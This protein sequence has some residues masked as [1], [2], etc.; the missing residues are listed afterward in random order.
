MGRK[1]EILERAAIECKYIAD[2]TNY[3]DAAAYDGFIIGA[4]W[5]DTSILD[6]VVDYLVEKSNE[7]IID[8]HH[9]EKFVNDLKRDMLK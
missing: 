2:T 8:L 5:V 9:N 7:G 1:E 6:K 3:I 4:S